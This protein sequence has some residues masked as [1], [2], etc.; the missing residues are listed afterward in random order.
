MIF[1]TGG[2]GLVGSRL[3]AQLIADETNE[4]VALRRKNSSLKWVEKVFSRHFHNPDTYLNR[5]Q[6][7]EGDLLDLFNLEQTILEN[8]EVYHVA[9]MVSFQKKDAAL[10][11]QINIEGTKNIV[12]TCLKN[13]VRKLVYVSSI[14]ALGRSETEHAT[15][16]T[17]Y[18]TSSKGSSVYSASKFEAEMEVWRGI[19]EGLPAVIINPS[20]ILGAGNWEQGSTELFKTVYRGLK[21]Y[22][23]GTNGYVDADDVAKAMILLMKSDITGE[24]FVFS[25]G[26]YSYNFLFE[27]IAKGL[28]VK[29]PKYFAS[30]ALSEIAWRI[31]A[32]ISFFTRRQPLITKETAQSANAFYNYSSEKFLQK[33]EFKFTPIEKTIA[34][35]C[36]EYLSDH[37][38]A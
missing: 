22:T 8:S 34:S 15:I 14:A 28:H 12:N 13:K 38:K 21:F 32:F 4:I 19:A 20:V 37:Q 18:R 30:P 24:R 6:W 10:V 33:T 31:L 1:V 16:E 11:R 7:V 17:D 35:V 2:T 36:K 5:I 9:A 3:L 26:N 27:T 29:A 23:R 25:Q